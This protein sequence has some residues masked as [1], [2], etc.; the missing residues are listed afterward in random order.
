M[1]RLGNLQRLFQ[2]TVPLQYARHA[3]SLL[4]EPVTEQSILGSVVPRNLAFLADPI[5]AHAL[6]GKERS[7]YPALP[8][9][10]EAE[11]RGYKLDAVAITT[12]IRRVLVQGRVQISKADVCRGVGDTLCFSP[13]LRTSLHEA[14]SDGT[15]SMIREYL[16]SRA[17]E[18]GL[19]RQARSALLRPKHPPSRISKQGVRQRQLP[20]CSRN[21]LKERR[22]QPQGPAAY[23]ALCKWQ[24]SASES[25]QKP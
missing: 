6:L 13:A 18:E 11:Q 14:L 25:I 16:A 5:I 10:A 2:R 1:R 12:E 9:L 17:A 8:S 22:A 15:K 24:K 7:M 4:D 23:K 3:T 20:A 19:P 21:S